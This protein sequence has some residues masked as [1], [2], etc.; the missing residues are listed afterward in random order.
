M[1]MH[2][3]LAGEPV[4]A[5]EEPPRIYCP[6][7]C[8]DGYRLARRAGAI[9][10]AQRCETCQGLGWTEADGSPVADADL[11][12]WAREIGAVA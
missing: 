5:C 10:A 1:S 9:V 12:V 2:G 11:L 6:A 3:M 4:A 7:G 8:D